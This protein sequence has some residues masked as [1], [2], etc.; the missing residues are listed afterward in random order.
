[1]SHWTR[2]WGCVLLS[3]PGTGDALLV[4]YRALMDESTEALAATIG[5]RVRK[6]RQ[7][8]C[9]TLDQLA[10]AAGVSRRMVVNVEQGAANPSVGT[11]LRISDALGVGLPALVE[12]P[13]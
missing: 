10:Q 5:A 13:Q 12:P 9:W 4:Q 8:R 11:L 1:M 3:D 6:E 7:S 2:L